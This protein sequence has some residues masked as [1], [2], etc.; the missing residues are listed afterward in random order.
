ML[1]FL[2]VDLAQGL[3]FFLLLSKV[4]DQ[5]PN[6]SQLASLADS[7]QSDASPSTEQT[8]SLNL[9]S[10]IGSVS[11]NAI[12]HDHSSESMNNDEQWSGPHLK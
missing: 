12:L 2:F 6:L 10:N 9:N 5:Q 7:Q 8:P 1:C 4:S 3:T 11:V